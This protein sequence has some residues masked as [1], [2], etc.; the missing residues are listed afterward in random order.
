MQPKHAYSINSLSSS[1]AGTSP[2]SCMYHYLTNDLELEVGPYE[3]PPSQNIGSSSQTCVH[4]RT[5]NQGR[6]D[7]RRP[8][9]PGMRKVETGTGR[10]GRLSEFLV[11]KQTIENVCFR[12]G[13]EVEYWGRGY[14]ICHYQTCSIFTKKINTWI[15]LVYFFY[16]IPFLCKY[17]QD[18]IHKP[19][20]PTR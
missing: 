15:E 9:T 2:L 20:R 12:E 13:R 1:T 3:S 7:A 10:S 6:E 19:S 14:L 16:S 5:I 4:L 8:Q 11:M 18:N 17:I